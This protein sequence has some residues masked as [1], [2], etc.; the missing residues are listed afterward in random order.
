MCVWIC[1][2][3]FGVVHVCECCVMCVSVVCMVFVCVFIECV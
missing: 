3:V 1:V 2:G